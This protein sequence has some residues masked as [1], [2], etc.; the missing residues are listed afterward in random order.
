MDGVYLQVASTDQ[1][2]E[3]A[4]VVRGLLSASHRS[5]DDF[6]VII[7]AELLAEQNAAAQFLTS[8]WSPSLP[9]LYS[10]AASES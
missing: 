3:T 4:E 8:L 5:A 10:S 9:F 6:S 7:A 2:V 1:S